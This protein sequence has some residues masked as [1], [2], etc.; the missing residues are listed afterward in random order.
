MTRR[1]ILSTLASMPL[2]VYATPADLAAYGL[3]AAATASLPPATVAAALDDVS[4]L[5][6]GYLKSRYTMP[7]VSWGSELTSAVCKIAAYN[8]FCVRGFNPGSGADVNL[9]MRHD[10]AMTWLKAV[11][12]QEVHPEVVDSVAP[13]TKQYQPKV[14]SKERRT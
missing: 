7:L 6:D 12:R 3:P 1:V 8:L 11:S 9:R 2:P 5:A 10:D 4:R 13:A 14:L